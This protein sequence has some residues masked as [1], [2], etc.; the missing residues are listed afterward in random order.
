ME[1]LQLWLGI[2]GG[3]IMSGVAIVGSVIGVKK[4]KNGVV[5]QKK[6]E[7]NTL[8][9]RLSKHFDDK[10]ESNRK[11]AS[12]EKKLEMLSQQRLCI[13]QCGKVDNMDKRISVV[14][15]TSSIVAQGVN[16]LVKNALEEQ[17][18]GEVK[19]YKRD[20]EKYFIN[21]K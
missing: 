1:N 10:F 21:N 6:I 12:S 15:H 11:Q 17:L 13:D 3:L 16:I 2:I 4:Y 18:N 14:E 9:D 8:F 20:F 19:D 7:E 5:K